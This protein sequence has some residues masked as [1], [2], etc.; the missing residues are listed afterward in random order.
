MSNGLF[1]TDTIFMIIITIYFKTMRLRGS[2]LEFISCIK[3]DGTGTEPVNSAEIES[4]QDSVFELNGLSMSAKTF[5]ASGFNSFVVKLK[6][7]VFNESNLKRV[8]NDYKYDVISYGKA[9]ELINEIF[10]KK[11]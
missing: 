4:V 8:L 5:I 2:E 3:S 10:Y 7:S 11:K 6:P 9:V 1:R